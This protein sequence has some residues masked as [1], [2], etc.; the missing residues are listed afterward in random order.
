[1]IVW[2]NQAE[3]QVPKKKKKKKSKGNSNGVAEEVFFR[4][5][6]EEVKE[7]K[8]SVVKVSQYAFTQLWCMWCMYVV[9]QSL[10]LTFLL[11]VSFSR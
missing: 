8:S 4:E 6:E 7:A 3:A 1:M 9:I 5:E 2:Q 10:K 11:I